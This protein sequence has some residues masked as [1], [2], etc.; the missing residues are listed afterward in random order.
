MM[1]EIA[2][3]FPLEMSMGRHCRTRQRVFA[4]AALGML[5][6]P[7]WYWALPDDANNDTIPLL[8]STGAGWSAL[9]VLIGLAL[10]PIA[11]WGCRGLALGTARLA[12]ATL[13]R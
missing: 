3:M 2:G 8:D 10:V 6:S 13:G 4:S 9:R 5:S 11:A 7:L 1:R 12:K